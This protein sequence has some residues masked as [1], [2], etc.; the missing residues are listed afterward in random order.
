MLSLCVGTIHIPRCCGAAY[1]CFSSHWR[2]ASSTCSR[3]NW[4]IRGAAFCAWRHMSPRRRSSFRTADPYGYSRRLLFAAHALEFRVAV[5]FALSGR[6]RALWPAV[7]RRHPLQ[8]FRRRT[9]VLLPCF[10]S[11]SSLCARF[12]NA[13]VQA[14]LK[15]WRRLRARY[16]WKGIFLAAMTVYAVYFVLSWNQSSDSL[17]GLGHNPAALLL[18]RLLLPAWLFCVVSACLLLA[19]RGQ[20]L[21]SATRTATAC[22]FI[23]LSCFCSIHTGFFAHASAHAAG[24]RRSQT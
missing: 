23:F 24:W 2:W 15:E 5:A 21:F 18:R 1:P 8:I 4:A 3:R 12:G 9:F 13:S 6:P 19:L 10:P 16:L 11:E 7:R 14:D 17:S 22:G 20:L